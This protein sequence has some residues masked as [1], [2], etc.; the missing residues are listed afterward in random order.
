[1]LPF[2]HFTGQYCWYVPC[3]T[4]CWGPA[5]QDRI[6]IIPF[7]QRE[8]SID[9]FVDSDEECRLSALIADT[10]SPNP[11]DR[12]YQKEITSIVSEAMIVLT[13]RERTILE[14]RYGLTGEEEMTLEAIG[15]KLGLSRERVR[16]L[17]RD[18]KH[19]LHQLLKPRRRELCHSLS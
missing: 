11:V 7:Y 4:R 19:K 3:S 8:R 14:D 15:Q 18:A 10:E 13:E 1:M 9:D 5:E 6:M 2:W 12:V 17:E 16:Q